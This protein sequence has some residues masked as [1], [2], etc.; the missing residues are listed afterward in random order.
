[1]RSHHVRSVR[2]RFLA[3]VVGVLL[4][5]APAAVIAETPPV[6]TLTS[7]GFAGTA[8]ALEFS[9]RAKPALT[10]ADVS[11][12]IDGT[13][14]MLRITGAETGRFWLE[15]DDAMIRRTL[16][17]PSRTRA[18]AAV[19]RVRLA[20]PMS[21]A[22]LRNIMVRVEGG[23]LVAQVPRSDAV[24]AAWAA[25]PEPV[26]AAEPAA[27]ALEVVGPPLPAAAVAVAKAPT[28]ATAPKPV[29]PTAASPTAAAPTEAAPTEAAP[30]GTAL[31]AATVAP[32]EAPVDVEETVLPAAAPL[33]ALAD[34][35]DTPIAAAM[36]GAP[37]EGPGVGPMLIALL[38]LA[39]VG[40]VMWRKLR[41][42]RPGGAQAPLIRP[43]G[44]H[45]LGPKQSLLLVDVAGEM[46]LLGTSDKGVQM[47]TKIERREGGLPA[48]L[49]IAPAVVPS[50]TAV[51]ADALLGASDATEALPPAGSFAEKLGRAVARIRLAAQP[52]PAE[53]EVSSSEIERD[54]F[55]REESALREAAEMDAIDAMADAVSDEAP[56]FTP[57]RAR[58]PAPA[59]RPTPGPAADPGA[60]DLLARI[61]QLQSA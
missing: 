24:A 31:A 48:A 30:T 14:L 35:E 11:A 3:R 54:F 29:A 20:K 57:R 2:P 55:A 15:T 28:T 12:S 58:R 25:T 9:M 44:T 10:E 36:A 59:R 49:A 34:A 50:E 45:L 19:V 41:T 53:D 22:M 56:A 5:A 42:A 38:F 61:R 4:A 47:L 39:G 46:V 26:V 52:A 6:K 21:A 18:P 16:V 33:A 7:V 27:L 37:S 60:N 51:P 8:D 23:A 32:S 40:F 13:V 1:M 43:V 17:H